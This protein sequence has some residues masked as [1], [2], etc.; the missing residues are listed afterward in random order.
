MNLIN[1]KT[2]KPNH[3]F[4]LSGKME[5]SQE[6][7]D[8]LKCYFSMLGESDDG[9]WVES[10]GVSMLPIFYKSV[11]V[12]VNTEANTF[13]IG[14]VVVFHQTNKFVA[15]RIVAFDSPNNMFVTKGDTLYFFDGPVTGTDI[16]GKVDFVLKRGKKHPVLSDKKIAEISRKIGQQLSDKLNWLPFWLKFIYYF[17]FFIPCYLIHTCTKQ[18][19]S[20]FL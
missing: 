5:S 10:K 11:R 15:H 4:Q 19:I 13:N 3:N 16:L 12:H 17:T 2:S 8:R 9:F 6:K 14:D 20:K 1:D 7:S 18:N